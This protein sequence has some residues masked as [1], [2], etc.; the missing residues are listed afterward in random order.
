MESQKL[1][2][3][4]E[5]DGV[6]EHPGVLVNQ[7]DVEALVDFGI[8]QVAGCHP[9][10]QSGRVQT[11]DFYLALAGDVPQLHMLPKLP[12]VLLGRAPKGFGQQHVINDGVT[13]HP[14]GIHPLSVGRAAV[15]PGNTTRLGT[16]L[17]LL[18]PPAFRTTRR[19]SCAGQSEPECGSAAQNRGP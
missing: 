11:L 14:K 18:T 6:V 7:R 1:L 15:A 10:Q 3:E 19:C 13:L 9:L 17:M 8:A 2:R 16:E 4:L 5:Q 12:V